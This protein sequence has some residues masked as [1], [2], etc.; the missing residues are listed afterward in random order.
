MASITY[1]NR[2]EPV[3]R[4]NSLTRALAAQ[5]RDPFWFLAR[6]WQFGEYRGQDAGSPA[7]IQ[8]SLSSAPLLG[9]QA[10]ALPARAMTESKEAPLEALVEAEPFTPDLATAVELGQ[11]FERYLSEAVTSRGL[12]VSVRAALRSAFLAAYPLPRPEE[13][14]ADA[15]RDPEAMRFLRV[16]GGRVIHGVLLHRAYLASH[17]NLPN[18]PAVDARHVE[19]VREALERLTEW[20]TSLYGELGDGDAVAWKPER[21][22]YGA[23][24]TA[25]NPAGGVVQLQAHPGRFGEFD[26]YAFDQKLSD[27]KT[28]ED[29]TKTTTHSVMPIHARFRGMPNA[30]WWQF[31]SGTINFSDIRVDLSES[32]KLIVIDYM[33]VHSNDWFVI[34]LTQRVGTLCRINTLLVH[35][36]FGEVTNIPKA[37]SPAGGWAMFTTTVEGKESKGSDYFLLPPTAPVSTQQGEALEEVRFLRDEMANSA[38]AVE[39]LVEN[40]L[41][42]PWDARARAQQGKSRREPVNDSASPLQYLVQTEVPENWI[43]FVPVRAGSSDRS[44]DMQRAA[45][46]RIENGVWR[47]IEPAGRILRPKLGTYKIREEEIPRE[48]VTVSRT[49]QR[50][51]W[52]DGSTHLWIFR[53]KRAGAG[54]GSSGLQYDSAI[55]KKTG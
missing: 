34:P 33:L 28:R 47:P 43:P 49:V 4:S 52:I 30:R 37:S 22:E 41:A 10:G 44:V 42:E 54:E 20:V 51:R 5:V 29:R 39:H 8:Y 53:N 16:C 6:Q 45:M 46:L 25:A 1:W 27:S 32:A 15:Q 2:I 3:P 18:A 21:L 55:P 14:G 31:E 19:A 13:L 24:L 26:W 38:W 12:P 11:Q 7:Y 9:W 40:G 48:G 50:V 23:Q 17:P 36:V 35:D